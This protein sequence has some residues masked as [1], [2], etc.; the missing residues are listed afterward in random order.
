[1]ESRLKLRLEA[2]RLAAQLSPTSATDLVK[3]AK[4]I[5]KY[6]LG[7]AQLPEHISIEEAVKM[8]IEEG[9]NAILKKEKAEINDIGRRLDD[10]YDIAMKR[11]IESGTSPGPESATGIPLFGTDKQMRPQ[12]NVELNPFLPDPSFA[13]SLM[14]AFATYPTTNEELN[15]AAR[16]RQELYHDMGLSPE[17]F[18]SPNRHTERP[19]AKGMT[20]LAPGGMPS[21]E[22]ESIY[23]GEKGL[24]HFKP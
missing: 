13:S 15:K 10:A 6:I 23:L 2:A 18:D 9:M 21:S 14:K 11:F 4:T 5:E 1:M 16:Q 22:G 3:K 8:N 20:Y 7:K 12:D 17:P 19:T 24:T